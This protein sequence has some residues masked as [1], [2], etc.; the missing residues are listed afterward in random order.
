ME[1]HGEHTVR[2]G[3]GNDIGDQLRGDR[4]TRLILAVLPGIPEI[5]NHGRNTVGR[6]ALEGIDHDE[7][8]HDR[9]VDRGTAGLRDEHIGAAH[10]FFHANPDFPVA[11]GRHRRRAEG[12]IEIRANRPRKRRIGAARKE[13]EFPVHPTPSMPYEAMPML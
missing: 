2:T 13:L 5:R 12:Q 11:E 9:I 4:H 3:R 1:I 10:V 7:H 8:F 6:R